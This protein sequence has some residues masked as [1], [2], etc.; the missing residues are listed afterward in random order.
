MPAT[1]FVFFGR[2]WGHGVGLAQYGALGY[3]QHGSTY[4]RILAHYYPG[5]ELGEAPVARVRVLLAEGRRQVTVASEVPFTLKTTTGAR[6]LQPGTYAVPG[7]AD[8]QLPIVFAPGR[9]PLVLDGHP[10]RGSLRVTQSGSTVQVVNI[11]GLDAYLYGVVASEMDSDW[12]AEALKAQAVAAR[13]YAMVERRGGEFDLYAD[14]RSQVYGGIDAETATARAA[15]DA[16]RR[17]VLYYD[18]KV[19][20][21]FFSASSGGR[22]ADITDI[23]LDSKPIPYLVSV[24]DPYDTVSPYH[25]WGPV[26]VHAT[27][28]AKALE[29]SGL[30]GLTVR[31]AP[32]QRVRELVLG[33]AAGRVTVAGNVFRRAL[34]LRSTWF[35]VGVLQ[36]ERV[37]APVAAGTTVR[38]TG[39]VLGLA[40]PELEQRVPGGD[41]ESVAAVRRSSTGTFAMVVRP[42]ETTDYRLRNGTAT[43]ESIRVTVA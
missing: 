29:V 4:D 25:A 20:Q 17:Q 21:T 10:Y 7:I 37:A 34:G 5:T 35:R 23:W 32:S 18:G 11:V 24:P 40:R 26:A 38:L 36:L 28:A 16:T 15:V 33:T 3:A 39:R 43:S 30:R 14:T 2:G 12:P 42:T 22:T 31:R 9:G 41:W 8:V 13:S 6:T 1:T 19:A 27:V